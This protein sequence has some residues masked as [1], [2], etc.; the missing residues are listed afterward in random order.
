MAYLQWL[1]IYTPSVL[2]TF[3]IS[4]H[5]YSKDFASVALQL[6]AAITHPPLSSSPFLCHL[7]DMLGVRYKVR[8]TCCGMQTRHFCQITKLCHSFLRT[9][10]TNRKWSWSWWFLHGGSCWW[11]L[12]GGSCMLALAAKRT[13]A[14]N[15]LHTPHVRALSYFALTLPL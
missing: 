13:V 12:H 7:T 6:K 9:N 10:K 14:G 4:P 15:K 5:K 11:F 1:F 2:F 8:I 3:S